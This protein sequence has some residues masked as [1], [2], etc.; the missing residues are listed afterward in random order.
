LAQGGDWSAVSVND[1]FFTALH[2]V[3]QG[4]YAN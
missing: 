4:T 3:E 2:A 1:D